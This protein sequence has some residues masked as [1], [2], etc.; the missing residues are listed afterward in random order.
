M[1]CVSSLLCALGLLIL[2]VVSVASAVPV[3]V[4]RV[5]AGSGELCQSCVQGTLELFNGVANAVLAGEV[6]T[7]GQ[8]CSH[9]N[10]TVMQKVCEAGCDAIGI[11]GL[12]KVRVNGR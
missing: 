12:I 5:G 1:R 9:V 6:G 7:C 10:G 11:A 4:A 3:E 2:L 8:L